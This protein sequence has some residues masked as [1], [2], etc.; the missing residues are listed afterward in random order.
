MTS[1]PGPPMLMIATVSNHVHS[2]NAASRGELVQ[3]P[4]A[5]TRA[6]LTN[7]LINALIGKGIEPM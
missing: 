3:R 5:H 6:A 1:P 4:A 7:P 2:G